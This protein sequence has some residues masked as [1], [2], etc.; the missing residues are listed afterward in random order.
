MSPLSMTGPSATTSIPIAVVDDASMASP[1]ELPI[2]QQRGQ[3]CQL[4]VGTTSSC[5]HVMIPTGILR[6]W[7]ISSQSSEAATS[8]SFHPPLY[9]WMKAVLSSSIKQG[10]G[11]L[12]SYGSGSGNDAAGT[13][14]C[15]STNSSTVQSP[16]PRGIVGNSIAAAIRFALSKT[17]TPPLVYG[18]PL[19]R[20]IQR[21]LAEQRSPS[22]FRKAIV[23][24]EATPPR[25]DSV[26]QSP[27]CGGRAGCMMH[28]A[29]VSAC[30]RPVWD[31]ERDNNSASV[32]DRRSD[33]TS[34]SS[35]CNTPVIT[36][37]GDI[38]SLP[39]R[40]S[41]S[42]FGPTLREKYAARSRMAAS[43]EGSV[44]RLVVA[45]S[46]ASKAP[47]MCGGPSS[48]PAGH[49]AEAAELVAEL[50]LDLQ[51][52]PVTA[53]NITNMEVLAHVEQWARE[54]FVA[55]RKVLHASKE[56]VLETDGDSDAV[57]SSKY[58]VDVN[59]Q[60]LVDTAVQ[61]ESVDTRSVVCSQSHM[62]KPAPFG[63]GGGAAA[64]ALATWQHRPMGRA[65]AS[66]AHVQ[67]AGVSSDMEGVRGG[68]VMDDASADVCELSRN[69]QTKRS[70]VMK[71]RQQTDEA[72]A[73]TG[74]P[75]RDSG[76]A[77]SS[78]KLVIWARKRHAAFESVGYLGRRGLFRA[79]GSR[80][81]HDTDGNGGRRVD[82][83]RER[84]VPACLADHMPRPDITPVGSSRSQREPS[85]R[86]VRFGHPSSRSTPL[87][88]TAGVMRV[89]RHGRRS[90]G[91]G[92]DRF[93]QG[94]LSQ[95]DTPR[96]DN[97]ANE[98]PFTPGISLAGGHPP[99]VFPGANGC[100]RGHGDLERVTPLAGARSCTGGTR[101]GAA[102]IPPS[103]S[104]TNRPPGERGP[105]AARGLKYPDDTVP[106]RT[107]DS[108]GSAT[109][110]T[111]TPR[112]TQSGV[113]RF[114]DK[115]MVVPFRP[116]GAIRFE[117]EEMEMEG[118]FS[119]RTLSS[120][121]SVSIIGLEPIEATNDDAEE[122][123]PSSARCSEPEPACGAS[124]PTAK[125]P[126]EW[127]SPL[128]QCLCGFLASLIPCAH[129]SDAV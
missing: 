59:T 68:A 65:P 51:L 6:T 70:P 67:F 3:S 69:D 117:D 33:T 62:P 31:Q 54:Q 28:V 92:Y 94:R 8:S 24:A 29:P 129:G 74:R 2:D 48:Q 89:T 7:Q 73:H 39:F 72:A 107:E 37:R 30:S 43:D 79:I 71:G 27:T 114:G 50:G 119:A 26:E 56:A 99:R 63:G 15:A 86:A 93:G 125:R 109:G 126:G 17:R 116:D 110:V 105:P 111:F 112:N 81:N 100:G 47:S 36:A 66:V 20:R 46:A 41:V 45:E 10:H 88:N 78:S 22:P 49:T 101:P 1:K 38:A 121:S 16:A 120:I 113:R 34:S 18:S 35:T 96:E 115:R 5:E 85:P 106:F 32:S 83:D 124:Q 103:C 64:G 75:P 58:P 23:L 84:G 104:A 127:K 98:A 77:E 90:Y 9:N 91:G 42:P 44:Q 80:R 128:S 97:A 11:R 12:R 76:N 53:N 13:Q 21:L 87:S 25:V 40:S 108:G 118:D 4:S 14:R 123:E 95:R 60:A 57:G 102:G 122:D 82:G 61:T 19:Y 52:D 55:A